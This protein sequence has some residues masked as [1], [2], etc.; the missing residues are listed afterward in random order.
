[1]A[2]RLNV[3]LEPNAGPPLHV[4]L[5]SLALRNRKD[6][7][8]DFPHQAGHHPCE[9]GRALVSLTPEEHRHLLAVIGFVYSEALSLHRALLHILGRHNVLIPEQ[10]EREMEEW[11]RL[12]RRDLVK[13]S[14]AVLKQ[15]YA[16]NPPSPPASPSEDPSS[17]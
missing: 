7:V 9:H 13:E 10:A 12:H 14:A 6:A 8:P 11:I 1:M 5:P 16:A 17:P 15:F 2:G 4:V 3:A